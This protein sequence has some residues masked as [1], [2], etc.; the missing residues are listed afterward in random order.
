M[1]GDARVIAPA[2]WYATL[3]APDLDTEV[4][5]DLDV[6]L[7][8]WRGTDAF[9]DK[10]ALSE[11][12]VC[13]HQGGAKRVHRWQGGRHEIWDMAADSVSLMPIFRANRWLT[14]GPVAFTHLTLSPGLLARFAREEFDREPADLMVADRVG[15]AEPLLASL[16]LA[17]AEDSRQ[18]TAGR[19]YRESLVTAIALRVLR[20]HSSMMPAPK[21]PRARGG[22][23]GWQLRRVLDYMAARVDQDVGV[24]DIVRVIG[25][26]R[27]HFFRAFRQSTGQTPS[28]Y[29]LSLRM[30]RAH[31]L[32]AE[33][34][35]GIGDVAR[36]VGFSGPEPFSRAFQRSFG[37]TP[38][39]WLRRHGVCPS[40]KFAAGRE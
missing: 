4:G 27:G 28:R 40:G 36:L 20:H 22:L 11:N 7:R 6:A 18:P 32:M 25:M 39:T 17:L 14:E 13:V 5:G 2:G 24:A 12:I 3:P 38:A 31:Q 21:V 37:M 1:S 34:S 16:L 29:M 33:N 9:M 35:I 8:S 19:L 15:A 26:S 30:E 10:P 23:A